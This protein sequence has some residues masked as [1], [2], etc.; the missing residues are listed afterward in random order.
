VIG[1]SNLAEILISQAGQPKETATLGTILVG[2]GLVV[3][4]V[5]FVLLEANFVH[6]V[7]RVFRRITKGKS[8]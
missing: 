1:K 3:A 8:S 7:A 5:A 4:I 2:T 6:L